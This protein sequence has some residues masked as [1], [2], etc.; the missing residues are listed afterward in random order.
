MCRK[1]AKKN[2]MEKGYTKA[3][4]EEPRH[5]TTSKDHPSWAG[6][7]TVQAAATALSEHINSM[8]HESIKQYRL[9]N[10]FDFLHSYLYI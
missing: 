10:F 7:T 4:E 1:P 2:V 9:L 5:Q 3:P 6:K 8:L